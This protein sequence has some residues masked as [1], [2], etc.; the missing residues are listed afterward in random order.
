MGKWNLDSIYLSFEG[1]YE[2]DLE[3]LN[4]LIEKYILFLENKKENDILYIENYLKYNEEILILVR[5]LSSFASLT[6][7][8]DVSNTKAY[9]YMSKISNILRQTTKPEVR[10]Q[11]YLENINLDELAN[12]S[13]LIKDHL[14]ILNR[15]QEN[16][17]Y[18][19]TEKEEELYSKMQEL[20]SGSW[21]QIHNLATSNLMIDV[22]GKQETFSSVRNMA[23]DKDEEVRKSAYEA[24]LKAYE[25]V[26]DYVALA[27]TNI[28]REV[29]LIN[30]LRGYDSVLEK[31]LIQ[32]KMKKETLDQMLKAIRKYQVE[33]ERYLKAKAEYL[34]HKNGLPFYDLF[35]PL[36][37]LTKTYTFDEAKELIVEAFGS[38]SNKLASFAKKAFN[39]N[40][41]DVFPKKGKRGGAFCSNLPQIKQSRIMLNYTG[42]LDDISTLAHELGH[43][44]HGDIIKDNSPLFWSYPMP[45]AETASIF[46][47]TIMK[48]HLINSLEKDEE[49]ISVLELGLQGETQVIIDILSRFIFESKLI[50]N[51]NRPISKNE[52]NSYMIDAQKEAYLNG[53]DHNVLH[54]YMW[55]V[56]GHYYSA[57]LNFYNFPYAFGLLF[58][59]GLYAI[60]L[61]DQETFLSDYDNLLKLTTM[62]NVED[63]ALEL[64]IDLSKE[65]FWLNSLEMI[66]KDIDLLID[67]LNK[68]K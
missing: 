13:K 54:K 1:K 19:L 65:E 27:L 21:N 50:E 4:K 63:V 28:K 32:S 11:R 36:G 10:F 48:N 37:S 5:N 60:Y 40:W 20:S 47:E 67:L 51:A 52:L 25:N 62:K 35:A 53:L 46:C 18:L 3:N 29:N 6:S 45:L 22:N 24:E 58:G 16:A 12:N 9:I 23:Y 43:G 44:Y 56:K 33:F 41:I 49:K 8:T 17:K 42:S 15:Q 26:D 30:E 66:K 7:A 34:G 59:K 14:Y 2:D 61:K 64:G 55:L 31:T 38:Y 68:S 57:G 39:D